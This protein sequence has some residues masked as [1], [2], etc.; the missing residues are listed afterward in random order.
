MTDLLRKVKAMVFG[1]VFVVVSGVSGV[2][3]AGEVYESAFGFKALFPGKWMVLDQS[4]AKENP[5]AVE[6]AFLAAQ[7]DKEITPETKAT[8]LS[9]KEMILR[10]EIEYYFSENPHFVV[11]V[12]KS[13]GTVPETDEELKRLCQSFPSELSDRAGKTINVYECSKKSFNGRSALLLIAD[14]QSPGSRYVQYQLRVDPQ[15]VII[16]TAT[17]A[18]HADFDKMASLMENFMK[19]VEL[20]TK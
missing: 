7:K 8:L 4:Y 2:V 17:G 19:S 6:S 11:A 5:D 13:A 20:K 10:G 16:F 14:G 18:Q 3:T 9:V 15:N 12:N 1:A